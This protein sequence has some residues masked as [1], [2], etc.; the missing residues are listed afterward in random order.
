MGILT[1]SLHTC[2]GCPV[3]CH[4]RYDIGYSVHDCGVVIHVL[5]SDLKCCFSAR[6]DSQRVL[7]LKYHCYYNLMYSYIATCADIL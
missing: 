3:Q 7:L 1:G 4:S 6:F 5:V 2:R